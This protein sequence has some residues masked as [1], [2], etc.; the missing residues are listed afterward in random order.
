MQYA[1]TK[2]YERM[3][4]IALETIKNS[5]VEIVEQFTHG[6]SNSNVYGAANRRQHWRRELKQTVDCLI[7]RRE[8]EYCGFVCSDDVNT[9]NYGFKK[10]VAEE[11]KHYLLMNQ[12]S[13]N[14]NN[15]H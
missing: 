7:L 8:K 14:N 11:L 9:A 5:G 2:A 15:D 4:G 13:G 6:V 3:R 1:F 12:N 10:R